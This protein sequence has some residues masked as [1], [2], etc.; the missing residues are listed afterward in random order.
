M[1][2]LNFCFFPL[3]SPIGCLVRNSSAMIKGRKYHSHLHNKSYCCIRDYLFR[4]QS[5]HY[6][7]DNIFYIIEISYLLFSSFL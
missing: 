7:L 3:G 5:V 6:S 2:W 1:E 4:T